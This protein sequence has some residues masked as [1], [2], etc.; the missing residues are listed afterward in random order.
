[1]SDRPGPGTGAKLAGIFLVLFG[2]GLALLGGG[3]SLVMLLEPGGLSG[4]DG[5]LVGFVLI[6]SLAALGAGF[7]FIWL[8]VK[9]MTGG[10]NSPPPA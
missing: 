4:R 9:L 8:G 1:M 3:C 2:L 10:F 7:A 6:L 5:A